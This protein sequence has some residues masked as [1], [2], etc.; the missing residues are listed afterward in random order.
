LECATA[1]AV[2]DLLELGRSRTQLAEACI[3]AET[4]YV[5]APT[6]GLDQTAVLLAT[7]GHA[8]LLDFADGSGRPVAWAPEDDEV[9]LLV[10]D[11]RVAHQH[12]SGGYAD[13]RSECERAAELLGVA[14]LALAREDDLGVLP[15]DLR[16]RARHVVSE[17][18]R[19]GA[20]VAAAGDGDWERVGVLMSASH[21]SL[22]DDFE[23]SCAELDAVVETALARGAL[24]ARM[25]GGG[26]G[27]SAIALVRESAVADVE[28]ALAETFT[29]NG[30][31][32]PTVFPVE[33][34]QSA[35]VA[36]SARPS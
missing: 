31:E 11:T 19:V 22:R 24:G 6:G 34:S 27:G 36:T 4:E 33:A 5:G 35:F 13:R 20:V 25:T 3:R 9:T 21:A 1:V 18:A 15:P 10:V 28:A 7:A 23:V 29:R 17:Q 8:L 14:A 12:A 16:P 2:N 32:A 26:F 30:W